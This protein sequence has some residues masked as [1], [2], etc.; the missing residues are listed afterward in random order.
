MCITQRQNQA[1]GC[2]SFVACG[3]DPWKLSVAS[4]CLL[5]SKAVARVL[6]AGHAGRRA[7]PA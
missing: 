3:C 7:R 2:S 4:R 5:R 1:L 6:R